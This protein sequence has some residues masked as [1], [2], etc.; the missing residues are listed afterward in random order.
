MISNMSLCL[1]ITLSFMTILRYLT[2]EQEHDL[3]VLFLLIELAQFLNVI[4]FNINLHV[5][6]SCDIAVPLRPSLMCDFLESLIFWCC[7]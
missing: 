3:L 6:L 4:N 7:V 2:I 1:I 5:C